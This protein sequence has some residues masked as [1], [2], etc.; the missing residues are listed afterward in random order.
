MRYRYLMFGLIVASFVILGGAGLSHADD[1]KITGFADIIL[2]LSDE[3]GDDLARDADGKLANS[4]NLKTGV[5]GEVDFEKAAGP[6]TFR[7]D[8]DVAGA[9]IEQAKFTYMI[10]GADAWGLSLT[11]GAF[12]APIG[13]EAQDAPDML[14]TSNGQLFGLVPS[15]LRGLMLS[16]GMEMVNANLYFAN[17]WRGTT[18]PPLPL[19]GGGLL[20]EENSIGGLVTVKPIE[21]ASLAVGYI[22]SP[23]KAGDGNVLDVV[24]STTA[25]P[26]LLIA[27][28]YLT[29]ENNTGLGITASYTHGPHV[30]TAR[31]DSV[32]CDKASG[33]KPFGGTAACGEAT[34]TSLTLAGTWAL[35]DSLS[36][37]LELRQDDPD[38]AADATNKAT[39][40]FVAKF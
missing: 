15:N 33:Y 7:M 21:M 8:L 27:L 17:E 11:G 5:T 29:D 36:G 3:S 25:V 26:N 14:Q 20:G 10:P 32:D 38:T 4:K 13:F 6:V 24:A 34:P 18:S 40:E 39:L 30:V 28:E 31:Y 16:G 9:A 1:L 2:T 35:T 12:N 37:V 22:T 19:P 23:E